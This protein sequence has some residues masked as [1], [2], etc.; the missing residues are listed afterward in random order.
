MRIIHKLLFTL[1]SV[2]VLVGCGSN[3]EYDTALKDPITLN[4]VKQSVGDSMYAGTYG[5][6]PNIHNYY[7]SCSLFFRLKTSVVLQLTLHPE[8]IG[9]YREI[10]CDVLDLRLKNK[11]INISS[12]ELVG[13]WMD[14]LADDAKKAEQESIK[15]QQQAQQQ[16]IET[17]A[18]R[19]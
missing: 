9:T 15:Q 3:E 16:Q 17:I 11:H 7:N 1:T 12:S 18:N 2:L 8:A 13:Y 6:S 19:K 4:L 5:I 10:S 14:K